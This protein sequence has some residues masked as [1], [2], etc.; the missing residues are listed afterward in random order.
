MNLI[1]QTLRFFTLSMLVFSVQAAD[2]DERQL[3]QRFAKI[4]VELLE[5]APSEMPGMLELT[6]NQGIFY[7][8]LTG[9]YFIPGTLFSLD[10]NGRFNDVVATRNGPKI[11]A[12]LAAFS[13]DMIVYPAENEKYIVTAFTDISCGYCL[14]LHREMQQY[15]DLGITVRYLAF[16]RAGARSDIGQ[17]MAKI[18][19]STDPKN[20]LDNAKLE[21]QLPSEAS[22][23]LAQCQTMIET[24]YQLGRD[25]GVTGTPAIFMPNGMNVG[26][27]IPAAGL[28]QRLENM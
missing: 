3:S 22:D 21:N 18:W 11:T 26:G 27:Y 2:Y 13:E 17:N 1:R 5:I 10:D 9:D 19:C 23:K 14:K 25:I 24:Q 15:N 8:T 12:A 7:S 16:P 20:A 28:L 6:T 4:G